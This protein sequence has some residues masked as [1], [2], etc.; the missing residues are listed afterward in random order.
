MAGLGLFWCEVLDITRM[1]DGVG[2]L[3]M[4]QSRHNLEKSKTSKFC[5]KP[6]NDYLTELNEIAH[7]II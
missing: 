3:S 6:Q 2:D 4:T 7:K 5:L 1:V